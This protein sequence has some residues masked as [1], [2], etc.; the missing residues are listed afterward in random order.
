MKINKG[1]AAFT[2]I[3]VLMSLVV[4]SI[5][6][7]GVMPTVI[8]SFK[9]I[10]QSAQENQQV[11]ESEGQ[12]QSKI[13]TNETF[14]GSIFP[15]KFKNENLDT[16]DVKG[17]LIK[18]TTSE[19]NYITFLAD[20]PYIKLNP[21]VLVEGYKPLSAGYDP[22]EL[23][24][25][26]YNT[27]FSSE[28]TE[29]NIYDKNNND[30]LSSFYSLDSIDENPTAPLDDRAF[31]ELSSGLTNAFSPYTVE[32][33]TER[34]ESIE[35]EE[36]QIVKAKLDILLPNFIAAGDSGR[37]VVSADG[38]YW[39]NRDIT[40]TNKINSVLKGN[41]EFLLLGDN[42]R[43]N[44]L[45]DEEDWNS[46]TLPVDYTQLSSDFNLNSGIYYTE[47]DDKKYELVSNFGVFINNINNSGWS[48]NPDV[49]VYKTNVT[50]LNDKSS[51]YFDN[52]KN[53]INTELSDALAGDNRAIFMVLQPEDS[54]EILFDINDYFIN[55]NSGE[56]MTLLRNSEN[57]LQ[58]KIDQD[59]YLLTDEV[60]NNDQAYL[61]TINMT[62]PSLTNI[63]LYING[64]ETT[65]TITN[66]Q[67]INTQAKKI[68]FGNNFKSN[69][70]FSGHIAEFIIYNKML[71]ASE[72]DA[73]NNYLLQKFDISAVSGTAPTDLSNIVNWL[74][75][76][77]LSSVS[78]DDKIYSL[79]S[80]DMRKGN[81]YSFENE[82]LN[83]I[84]LANISN[85]QIM[86]AVGDNGIILRKEN[87]ENWS[88]IRSNINE[89]LN[90]VVYSSQLGKFIAVGSK[91][92]NTLIK[93]SDDG[94]S[95]NDITLTS[96]DTDRILSSITSYD[97]DDSTTLIAVGDSSSNNDSIILYSTDGENWSE[98]S[99]N[100]DNNLKDI[101]F[102]KINE[103]IV[104]VVVGDNDPIN[105]ED[106]VILY[107][108]DGQSWIEY[109]SGVYDDSLNGIGR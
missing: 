25:D 79:Q 27:N 35:A 49:P 31:I 53:S 92:G 81:T 74:D 107:S 15:V 105:N 40:S 32:M 85:S 68:F 87:D 45:A 39:V 61:I 36:P 104:Y 64:A 4:V 75:A 44:I 43:I 63:D 37:T 24:V 34:D 70:Q 90:E 84:T 65:N 13:P 101:D 93:I 41:E 30:I 28:L 55:Q 72:L 52:K 14:T 3:E 59:S 19:A 11:L 21:Y 67:N 2:L 62:G 109:N 78:N 102:K 12:V 48:L 100:T 73:I 103:E 16:I 82:A 47:E 80:S 42:G 88:F 50:E 17:S 9:I 38:D 98:Y 95:W 69:K 71:S 10:N 89:S 60:V 8:E 96:I 20:R 57:K 56:Q 5:I 66:D 6:I 77:Y 22:S 86:V 91:S 76:E 106:A 1:T 108:T 26:A 99:S 7:A 29:L 23:L 54:A 33:I 18:S 94:H 58:L 83:S 46:I 97:A 51:L